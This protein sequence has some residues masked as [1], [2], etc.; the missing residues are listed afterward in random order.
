ML[1]ALTLACGL[2]FHLHTFL[3]Q[4]LRFNPQASLMAFALPSYR[5]VKTTYITSS[6]RPI[7]SKPL[8][9]PMLAVCMDGL[10][11]LSKEGRGSDS[12]K[13]QEL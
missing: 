4:S 13:K 12:V 1:F 6:N 11:T 2:L 10:T 3:F 9:K 8:S 7:M 5:A